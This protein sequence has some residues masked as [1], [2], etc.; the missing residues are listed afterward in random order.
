MKAYI[1]N[2][3]SQKD[4]S[5]SICFFVLFYIFLRYLGISTVCMVVIGRDFIVRLANGF[6]R[7]ID[8]RS[9]DLYGLVKAWH[10]GCPLLDEHQSA[11]F[12]KIIF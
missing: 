4:H 8:Y 2:I 6:D 3:Y 12:R 5:W 1:Y 9:S 10:Q 7:E 11:K